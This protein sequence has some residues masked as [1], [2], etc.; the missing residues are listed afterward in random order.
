MR[1]GLGAAVVRA[2][3]SGAAPAHARVRACGAAPDALARGLVF[4]LVV[5]EHGLVLQQVVDRFLG[6]RA[7]A[8]VPAVLLPVEPGL[9]IVRWCRDWLGPVIHDNRARP[10]TG[11]VVQAREPFGL[12]LGGRG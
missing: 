5:V 3:A 10:E 12:V 2:P 7:R 11:R 4:E 6:G 8:A 1:L 9:V